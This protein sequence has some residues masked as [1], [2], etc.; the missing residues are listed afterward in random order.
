MKLSR[1][2]VVILSTAIA[3]GSVLGS[4]LT[5]EACP[6]RNSGLD[7]PS[8]QSDWNP[9]GAARFPGDSENR[10]DGN[11]LI[12]SSKPSPI[13]TAGVLGFGAIASLFAVGLVYKIRQFGST[14]ATSDVLLHPEFEHPELTLTSI[15]RE[16][17]PTLNNSELVL[18]R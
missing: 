14:A 4:M 13:N 9:N 16:A 12:A 15:P 11:N 7:S 8:R 10:T 1:A 2:W 18:T 3:S 17:L 6:Y 5:A